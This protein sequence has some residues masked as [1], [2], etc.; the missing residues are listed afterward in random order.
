MK[1]TARQHAL[2]PAH[3]CTSVRLVRCPYAADPR[4]ERVAGRAFEQ[5]ERIA[6]REQ[7][8]DAGG[9]IRGPGQVTLVGD[10]FL[11]RECY[12]SRQTMYLG[13]PIDDEEMLARLPAEY[14]RLLGEVNGYVAYHGGLHVRGACSTPE[15]HSLRAAWFG[16]EAI[17]R[18]FPAVSAEDVP[19][20]EDAL[21]DQFV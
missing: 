20:A 2:A 8:R 5:H 11:L 14:R 10:F 19:F 18:Q 1:P 12:V 13:P 21:G 17:H 3:A 9:S 4:R 7:A 16:E 6:Y 15:W